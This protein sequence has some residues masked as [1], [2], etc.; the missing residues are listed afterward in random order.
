MICTGEEHEYSSE[1]PTEYYFIVG[2]FFIFS[3]VAT[4]YIFACLKRENRPWVVTYFWILISVD[5]VLG[6]VCVLLWEP[7][8]YFEQSVICKICYQT[9]CSI[10]LIGH[11]AFAMEYYSAAI[12]LPVIINIFSPEAK[13]A[14]NWAQKK[15]WA[16]NITFYGVV[17]VWLCLF[18]MPF[19][20]RV[21][22][23]NFAIGGLVLL[24]VPAIIIIVSIR[25]LRT[26]IMQF[27]STQFMAK[28]K[29]MKIHT[30]LYVVFTFFAFLSLSTK[31]FAKESYE[32]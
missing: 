5:V 22:I 17:A 9:T 25:R 20:E 24:I 14:W 15:I 4:V 10:M 8:S 12:R 19:S 16:I 29:L 3:I 32:D 18:Q 13:V 6:A 23:Y 27:D 1:Y 11:F 28:E 7:V 21:K 30:I 31:L 26:L 2:A